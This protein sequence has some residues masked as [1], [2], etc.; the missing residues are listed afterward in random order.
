MEIFI[1]VVKPVNGNDTV[2]I[3]FFGLDLQ[4]FRAQYVQKWNSLHYDTAVPQYVRGL[5]N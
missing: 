1:T 2:L 4:T 5:F 3:V